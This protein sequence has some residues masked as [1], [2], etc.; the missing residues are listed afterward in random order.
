MPQGW[1]FAPLAFS[2]G[3]RKSIDQFWD[4]LGEERGIP[5]ADI[6]H[7]KLFRYLDDITLIT[8]PNVANTAFEILRKILTSDGMIPNEENASPMPLTE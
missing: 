4:K 1:P 7:V 2:L 6:K 8:P 3:L 5:E